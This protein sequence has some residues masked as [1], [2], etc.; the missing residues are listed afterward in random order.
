MVIFI[1]FYGLDWVATVPPTVALCREYFGA[2]GAVVFGWVFASHQVGAAI[3]ATSAGLVRDRLGDYD[4]A[5]YGAGALAVLASVLSLMLLAGKR[6]ERPGPAGPGIGLA[7]P[8]V[9]TS[10]APAS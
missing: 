9:T 6:T 5:W 3:A 2:A 4:W 7:F 10:A 1:L 8:A